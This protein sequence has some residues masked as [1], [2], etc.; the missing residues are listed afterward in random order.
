MIYI[1]SALLA[2][3]LA[4]VGQVVVESHDQH[5]DLRIEQKQLLHKFLV[6]LSLV[7]LLVPAAIRYNVG[8]DFKTYNSKV[9]PQIL[10]GTSTLEPGYQ[11]L[12]KIGHL[13][14]LN[15]TNQSVFI[16][17]HLVILILFYSYIYHYSK[18]PAV[19][20]FLIVG[21]TFYAFSLSGMRQALATS[22]FL[23]AIQYIKKRQLLRYYICM[24]VAI[25]FHKSAIIYLVM[26]FLPWLNLSPV[27]IACLLPVNF[28]LTPVYR[29]LLILV[30]S[31]LG[32]YTNYF[33]AVYDQGGFSISQAIEILFILVL[34]IV[35]KYCFTT[36]DQRDMKDLRFELN[37]Q[38]GLA[39]IVSVITILPSS[40]RILYLLLP[41][42]AVL[43]P[44]LMAKVSEKKI[45]WLLYLVLGVFFAIY[46]VQTLFVSNIY[47]G[48]PFEF[49]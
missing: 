2:S 26:Y 35:I 46:L 34:I 32:L 3:L 49:F 24:A 40:S 44:N 19:S 1:V 45:R 48:L 18:S 36:Q 15:G 27:L 31:K 17:T 33:G 39:L 13:F 7:M 25:S 42:Q 28:V 11:L 47:G 5:S 8:I 30:T 14:D 10:D 41:V 38:M 22:V 43:I 20:V 4:Y 16:L 29:K 6:S 21:T 23:F 9:I 37:I 12:V